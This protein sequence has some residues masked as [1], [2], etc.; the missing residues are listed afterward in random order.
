MQVAISCHHISKYNMYKTRS[1]PRC[2]AARV[3][4]G[5]AGRGGRGGGGG[6][7]PAARRLHPRLHRVA[8]AHYYTLVRAHMVVEF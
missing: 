6:A 5:R 8:A 2:D 4:V 1:P 3:R 7:A